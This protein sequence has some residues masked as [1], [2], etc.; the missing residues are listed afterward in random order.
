M[1]EPS[2]K[3]LNEISLHESCMTEKAPSLF[4]RLWTSS[5]SVAVSRVL[6]P[7]A[8]TLFPTPLLSTPIGWLL[9]VKV[10]RIHNW[11]HRNFTIP[12]DGSLFGMYGI[13]YI[14][15]LGTRQKE[16]KLCMWKE[17]DISCLFNLKNKKQSKQNWNRS[18]TSS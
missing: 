13:G 12:S 8:Y 2:E 5:C 16:R 10:I 14:L 15:G 7:F 4:P 11:D 1:K 3:E 18:H 6:H 9:P 17:S